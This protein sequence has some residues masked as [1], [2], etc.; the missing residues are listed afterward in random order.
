[1]ITNISVLVIAVV[2]AAMLVVMSAMNGMT[3]LVE[4]LYANFNPDLKIEIKEG[5][6]FEW[7]DF[8][9]SQIESLE[10]VKGV[11]QVQEG[12]VL[13]KYNNQQEVASLKGVSKDY[14]SLSG[15]N[16]SL[17]DPNIDFDEENISQSILGAGLAYKLGLSKSWNPLL[18]IYVPGNPKGSVLSEST[19]FNQ[20]NVENL[21]T[22]SVNDEFD[23]KFMIVPLGLTEK[24]F[25]LKGRVHAVEVMLEP[26]INEMAVKAQIAQLI[27]DN[28]SV[29]TRF[30]QQEFLF[31]SINA[32]KWIAFL[33]LLFILV[34]AIFNLIGSLIMLMID[35]QKDIFILH[36]M[37]ASQTTIKNIFRLE[38]LLITALGCG[39]GI[40]LGSLLIWLQSTF[41]FIKIGGAF[42]INAYPVEYQIQDV[43]VISL[44]VLIIGIV[45]SLIPTRNI[46][47]VIT[48]SV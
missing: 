4:S 7:S 8:D 11:V 28:Y 44:A 45:A 42:V 24:L 26:G 13:L 36:S 14:L 10:G 1:M 41:A 2:C 21:G 39:L 27:P 6:S 15:L 43:L 5:K 18:S 31:R 20:V 29:K 47:G 34:I 35:K 22:F 37:G 25:D 23:T 40:L 46:K 19:Y 33:I 32:E 16:K 17:N 12:V 9:W 38:G 48:K 3:S 30:E